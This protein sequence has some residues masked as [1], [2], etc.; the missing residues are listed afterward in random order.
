MK[1]SL[2]SLTHGLD[3]GVQAL[4]RVCEY[5]QI[6]KE[7]TL[8]AS[9]TAGT[10][11]TEDQ[12]LYFHLIQHT[13]RQRADLKRIITLSTALECAQGQQTSVYPW[14]LYASCRK[15]PYFRTF[16]ITSPRRIHN[17]V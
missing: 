3:S 4:E 7:L 11:V 6:N 1:P 16:H 8:G 10:A 12:F 15:T 14:R 17:R 13:K 9:S 2:I 5:W